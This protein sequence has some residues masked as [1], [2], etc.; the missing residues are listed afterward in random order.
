MERYPRPGERFGLWLVLSKGPAAAK[1]YGSIKQVWCK[2]RCGVK[3]LVRVAALISGKSRG[4]QPC[5][6]PRKAEFIADYDNLSDEYR[7]WLGMHQRCGNHK[8]DAYRHY[9]GRGITV[10]PRWSGP[11]GYLNF[12]EDMGRRPNPKLS[13]DRID[14]NSGYRADNCRWATTAQQASNRRF[15][16]RR[17][18][19]QGSISSRPQSQALQQRGVH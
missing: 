19:C 2:C 7:I 17:T 6:N 9:G 1:G 4:C 5:R 16:Q 14:N 12:L 10:Y 13:L 11:S 3:K 8:H 18:P 15:P